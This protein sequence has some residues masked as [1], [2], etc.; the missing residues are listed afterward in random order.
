MMV[1]PCRC[2][3]N[4]IKKDVQ[5]LWQQM[6]SIASMLLFT[7]PGAHTC[8]KRRAEDLE[9]SSSLVRA[10]HVLYRSCIL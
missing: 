4:Q 8:F 6:D 7:A 3:H 10:N 9:R 1:N 5:E 2:D